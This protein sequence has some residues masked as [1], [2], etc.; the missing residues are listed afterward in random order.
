MLMAAPMAY[1]QAV[2]DRKDYVEY[3]KALT[4]LVVRMQ[5]CQKSTNK[6]DTIFADCLVKMSEQRMTAPQYPNRSY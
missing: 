5:V 3:V 1:G 6:L 2:F 4:N